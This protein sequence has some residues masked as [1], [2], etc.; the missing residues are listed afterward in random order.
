MGNFKT[1]N[2]W[3][4]CTR[5]YSHRLHDTFLKQKLNSKTISSYISTGQFPH[6]FLENPRQLN[7]FKNSR[8]IYLTLYL[9]LVSNRDT[10]ACVH[11]YTISCFQGNQ[12]LIISTSMLRGCVGGG[13]LLLALCASGHDGQWAWMS[14]W[15]YVADLSIIFTLLISTRMVFVFGIFYHNLW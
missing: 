13:E 14:R 9:S 8:I 15:V 11:I 7:A 1:L 6:W 5:Y 10:L 4:L 2:N 12:N 3:N